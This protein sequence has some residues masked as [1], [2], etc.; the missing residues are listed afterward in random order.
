LGEIWCFSEGI[1]VY[2]QKNKDSA[3]HSPVIKKP[4]NC[5]CCK[6]GMRAVY[7]G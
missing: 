7:C 5:R 2:S 6:K 3:N 4:C 1:K